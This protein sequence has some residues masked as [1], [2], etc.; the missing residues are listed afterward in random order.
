MEISEQVRQ[1]IVANFYVPDPGQLG[2]ETSLLDIGVMDSTGVLE[3]ISFLENTYGISME[4][5]DMIAENLDSVAGI[6]NYL[7]RRLN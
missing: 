2:N 4:E 5:A 6:T 3:V 1:F 7:A